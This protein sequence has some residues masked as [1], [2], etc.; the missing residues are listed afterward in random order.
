MSPGTESLRF[1]STFVD[2]YNDVAAISQCAAVETLLTDARV[3]RLPFV[4]N[5]PSFRWTHRLFQ[6][7]PEIEMQATG[8]VEL[9]CAQAIAMGVL[10]QHFARTQA[11]YAEYNIGDRHQ[12]FNLEESGE[13]HTN[14]F[15]AYVQFETVRLLLDH[16]I[17]VE[18]SLH[19]R[20]T[21]YERWMLSVF[22]SSKQHL[23]TKFECT[24]LAYKKHKPDISSVARRKRSYLM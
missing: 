24:L 7:H 8:P 22:S 9:V 20:H 2:E 12:I 17:F 11:V 21:K 23:R 16:N 4:N 6:R 19:T 13:F 14:C 15:K 10:A 5:R 1:S 3:T 18:V